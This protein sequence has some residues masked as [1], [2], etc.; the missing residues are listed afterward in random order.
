MAEH[1]RA[2]NDQA[3]VECVGYACDGNLLIVLDV[4]GHKTACKSIWA[5]VVNSP[6]KSLGISGGISAAG[7]EPKRDR[8]HAFWTELPEHNAHNVL[9]CHARVLDA[10][11]DPRD[12][13]PFYLALARR[14]LAEGEEAADRALP[15]ALA[16][17]FA[18][19]LNQALELPILPAWAHA[20]W[21]LGLGAGLIAALDCG[22]DVV[23]AHRVQP[24]GARWARVIQDA[25]VN[26]AI[27]IPKDRTQHS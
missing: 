1:L 24:D 6:R 27:A 17:R 10:T 7:G 5:T 8:Y 21:D 16:Q 23:L 19:L 12:A 13:R 26:G 2:T 20:L 9:I 25:L 18:A 14:D 4:V 15:V 3:A 22:G 11:T